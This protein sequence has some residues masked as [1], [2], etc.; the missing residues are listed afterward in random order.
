MV[1]EGNLDANIYYALF[2]V[3]RER[4]QVKEI[5]KHIHMKDPNYQGVVTQAYNFSTQ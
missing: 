3:L 2:S 4:S 5:T 1:E